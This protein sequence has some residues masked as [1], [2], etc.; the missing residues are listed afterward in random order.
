LNFIFSGGKGK[1]NNAKRE[2]RKTKYRIL[3]FFLKI[4][5]KKIFFYLFFVSLPQFPNAQNV[6]FWKDI[7]N[8]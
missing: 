5:C 4:I 1:K 7:K 2:M 6:E 3:F 8:N